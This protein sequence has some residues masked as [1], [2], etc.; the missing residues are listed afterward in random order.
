MEKENKKVEWKG[1]REGRSYDRGTAEPIEEEQKT[2]LFKIERFLLNVESKLYVKFWWSSSLAKK[3][4][5][6]FLNL[7][8]IHTFI[9]KSASGGGGPPV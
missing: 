5:F 4:T 6:L 8:K 2:S 1:G 3:F 9:P 7:A